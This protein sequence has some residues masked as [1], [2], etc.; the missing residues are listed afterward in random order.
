[1]SPSVLIR[2]ARTSAGLTQTQLAERLGTTQPVVARLEMST[3]NPTLA[4][5][6]RA[7]DAAG[8][9]LEFRALE[10][11]R[12]AVDETQIIERLRW[13]PAQRLAAFTASNRN[14]NALV[15]AARRSDDGGA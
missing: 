13:T 4:T 2:Q 6:E 9:Q 14:I 15:R 7:L 10:R 3:A 5:I 11:P 1:M 12:A 8:Y